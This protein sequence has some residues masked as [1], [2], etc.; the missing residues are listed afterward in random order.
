MSYS[1]FAWKGI[2]RFFKILEK[3]HNTRPI[4]WDLENNCPIEATTS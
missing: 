1:E 2:A 4:T 3:L